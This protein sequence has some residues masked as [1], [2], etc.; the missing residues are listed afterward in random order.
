MF[1]QDRPGDA[2][3]G[4]A[5]DDAVDVAPDAAVGGDEPELLAV[6]AVGAQVDG[7]GRLLRV[8]NADDLILEASSKADGQKTMLAIG[9]V[10]GAASSLAASYSTTTGAYTSASGGGTFQSTT[11][12]PSVALAGASAAGASAL[13]G[14]GSI[15]AAR[16]DRIALL[17]RSYLQ[18]NT[19]GSGQQYQG[20]V[21]ANA[22][23]GSYP[24]TL[25]LNVSWLGVPHKFSWSL[26]HLSGSS[27]NARAD[28]PAQADAAGRVRCKGPAG[29]VVEVT[30]A[31]CAAGGGSVIQDR[32][33][34]CIGPI[35]SSAHTAITPTQCTARGGAVQYE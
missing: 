14:M 17:R 15:N 18:T 27:G 22:P 6:A 35:G 33:W 25:S 11:Y 2:D 26:S 12:D 23:S 24:Q 4:P 30:A 1:E 31:M 29:E 21:I 5:D 3:I 32:S 19:I 20:L 7:A 13:G 8:W 9:A 28:A 16:D 10:L 34:K